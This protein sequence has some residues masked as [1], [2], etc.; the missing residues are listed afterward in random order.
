MGIVCSKCGGKTVSDQVV[1]LFCSFIQKMDFLFF[2]LFLLNFKLMP[3]FLKIFS[4][5]LLATV[6]YFYTPLFA[7]L[8]GLHFWESWIAMVAGGLSSF[9]FFYYI[10]HFIVI[11]TKYVKPLTRRVTPKPWF[12]KYDERKKRKAL[13]AKPK[14]KFNKRNRLIIKLRRVGVWAIILTTPVAISIPF[15]AFLL[16]KYYRQRKG[17]VLLALFFIALEGFLLC[18]LVWNIPGLR[19]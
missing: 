9:L 5:F 10:S 15:G 19:P 4:V 12:N 16:R 13:N 11:S 18:L 14:K 6:K 3:Y 7:F 1:I 17:A 2:R 8:T